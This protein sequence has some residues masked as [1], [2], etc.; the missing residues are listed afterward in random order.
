MVIKVKKVFEEPKLE[1][2]ECVVKDI[3]TVSGKTPDIDGGTT[4]FLEAWLS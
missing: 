3:I 4:G 2:V 1:I